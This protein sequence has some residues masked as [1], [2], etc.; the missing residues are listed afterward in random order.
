MEFAENLS[1]A[2]V[3]GRV[4]LGMAPT[5]WTP[6]GKAIIICGLVLGMR[7]VHSKGYIHRDLKPGNIL[8][9][10][11]GES[12][13]S[14]FGTV[15]SETYDATLTP[16]CGTVYYSA[17][18]CFIEGASFTKNV[19]VFSFGSILYEIITE[20]A[21]LPPSTAP[22]DVIRTFRSGKMPDVPDSCGPLMQKLIPECW[23]ENPE[24]RPS[25]DRI[26]ADFE[27]ADFQ[28]IPEASR[29]EVRRY[30]TNIIRESE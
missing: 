19:D 6:T 23:S 3:F 18:E 8:I 15:R 25:F 4:G 27:N 20:K 14:D 9:N 7:F 10:G 30:V 28:I 22:F 16:E 13:I 29:T 1:L 2:R 11:R 5:F 17:P 26:I 24:S 12:L 21:V